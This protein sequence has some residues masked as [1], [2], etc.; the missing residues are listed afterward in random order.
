MVIASLHTVPLKSGFSFKVLFSLLELL[1]NTPTHLTRTPQIW[2]RSTLRV[3]KVLKG[4]KS[5]V[6]CLQYD[7]KVV[8]SGSSDHTVKLVHTLFL[9]ACCT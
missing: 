6:R 3:L 1:I 4:H 7:E 8:I 5:A 9:S 2:D